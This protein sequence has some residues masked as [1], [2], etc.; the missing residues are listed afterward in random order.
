[1]ALD[2]HKNEYKITIQGDWYHVP[3]YPEDVF[4]LIPTQKEKISGSII[5]NNSQNMIIIH[6]DVLIAGTAIGESFSCLR[7]S[8]L[9]N[10]SKV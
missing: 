6:P 8:V 2:E 3:L 1:M 4:N 9:S 10:L 5:V 7:K